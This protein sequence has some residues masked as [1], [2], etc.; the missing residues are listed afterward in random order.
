MKAFERDGKTVLEGACAITGKPLRYLLDSPL[1][2]V[3][4]LMVSVKL[5]EEIAFMADSRYKQA[6]ALRAKREK[7]NAARRAC[8]QSIQNGFLCLASDLRAAGYM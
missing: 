7:R 5:V 4:A 1:R 2:H 6:Q 8:E 3:Q